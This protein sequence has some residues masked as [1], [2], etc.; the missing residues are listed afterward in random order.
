[1]LYKKNISI[2]NKFVEQMAKSDINVLL[3]EHFNK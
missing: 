2:S 3:K 1:M